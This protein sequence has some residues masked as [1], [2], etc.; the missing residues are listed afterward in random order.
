M[1]IRLYIYAVLLGIITCRQWTWTPCTVAHQS[2]MVW[3]SC[4]M[5]MTC[6]CM[7]LRR[8]LLNIALFLQPGQ[9]HTEVCGLELPLF[10][11]EAIHIKG[12]WW[13]IFVL[14]EPTKLMG[15]WLYLIQDMYLWPIWIFVGH[16]LATKVFMGKS[17]LPEGYGWSQ[18][19]PLVTSYIKSILGR[20]CKYIQ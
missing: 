9:S 5:T 12:N 17:W 1:D 18:G 19:R 10:C 4:A 16:R 14:P 3:L 20:V 6:A 11:T 2:S 8:E 15:T 7:L 13:P